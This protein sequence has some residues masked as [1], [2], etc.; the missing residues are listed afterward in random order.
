MLQSTYASIKKPNNV[1][2]FFDTSSTLR[3]M[4]SHVCML[5][6]LAAPAG[7]PCRAAVVQAGRGMA[8][9]KRSMLQGTIYQN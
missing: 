1:S 2:K 5:L 4:F 9:L 3:N 8:I 6:L 7:L